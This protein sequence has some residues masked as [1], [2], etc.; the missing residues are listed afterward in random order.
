[1]AKEQQPP[2]PVVAQSRQPVEHPL[3]GIRVRL[4]VAP[5]MAIPATASAE[6]APHSGSRR[7]SD[8][9]GARTKRWAPLTEGRPA[10][11]P[12][13]ASTPRGTAAEASE[14]APTSSWAKVVAG[15]ATPGAWAPT[16]VSHSDRSP[17]ALPAEHFPALGSADDRKGA[18]SA[19]GQWKP[20][21][22]DES[23]FPPTMDATR[24]MWAHQDK[25]RA[26]AAQREYE[27]ELTRERAQEA[28]KERVRAAE[29]E[30]RRSRAA[31]A[32]AKLAKSGTS[33]LKLPVELWMGIF[34]DLTAQDR[35]NFARTCK[36]AANVL[37]VVRTEWRMPSGDFAG[38]ET[39]EKRA[40]GRTA[41]PLGKHA[42][43]VV[44]EDE[45][46]ESGR[47]R[48]RQVTMLNQLV[49]SFYN[50][51]DH[52]RHLEFWNVS[53]LTAEL[54]E[55]VAPSLP[56]L[57]YLGKGFR[58]R[59]EMKDV[60]ST[61]DCLGSGVF[62]C[63]FL[64]VSRI[65]WLLYSIR[66]PRRERAVQLD[67]WPNFNGNP[68]RQTKRMLETTAMLYRILPEARAQDARL[69]G[70]GTAFE[71]FLKSKGRMPPHSWIRPMER[72]EFTPEIVRCIAFMKTEREYLDSRSS[73]VQMFDCYTCGPIPG[74][75]FPKLKL[76]RSD[77]DDYLSCW[78]CR[79][80]DADQHTLNEDRSLVDQSNM[81]HGWVRAQP[82]LEALVQAAR[83]A[84]PLPESEDKTW[85]Q[86]HREREYKKELQRLIRTGKLPEGS[87]TIPERRLR[88]AKVPGPKKVDGRFENGQW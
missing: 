60:C 30:A 56:N 45:L 13:P 48:G 9:R 82:N 74:C 61:A 29:L 12:L 75:F 17:D 35:A 15:P 78:G 44:V 25:L 32:R 68:N 79:L 18:P 22:V 65:P 71:A 7:K 52:I 55:H 59:P 38:C 83:T 58:H 85:E 23:A 47:R 73:D 64:T 84:K 4:P 36:E 37:S 69:L 88:W 41:N 72:R 14:A 67:F 27:E 28:E 19:T 11:T 87:T 49:V 77:D 21:E 34:L 42:V 86:L 16:T 8:G 66:V 51:G 76:G 33:Q 2:L 10:Q 20:A 62:R 81:A 1:M 31:R 26:E 6:A 43:T 3:D 54:V 40:L 80:M 5:P 70:P 24:L 50:M 39:G 63:Q 46:D 53:C 57:E